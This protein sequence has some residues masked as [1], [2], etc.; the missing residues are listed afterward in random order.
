MR[1]Q[2]W[3]RQPHRDEG[4]PVRA[5]RAQQA[6]GLRRRRPHFLPPG[7]ERVRAQQH[8]CSAMT[9]PSPL[10]ACARLPRIKSFL[11]HQDN[12][13][14]RAKAGGQPPRTCMWTF[15]ITLAGTSALLTR[16]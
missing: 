5:Q 4:G 1:A 16:K 7:E 9:Q 13:P 10:G 15:P 2:A 11:T 8:L 3:H 12:L 14:Q 6:D